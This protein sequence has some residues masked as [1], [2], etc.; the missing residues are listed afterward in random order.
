MHNKISLKN[1]NIYYKKKCGLHFY[2]S[3]NQNYTLESSFSQLVC[4]DNAFKIS[5]S[6]IFDLFH[7][8]IRVKNLQG[9]KNTSTIKYRFVTE[10]KNHNVIYAR[11][12]ESSHIQ[13]T[14][15]VYLWKNISNSV[16]K[17]FLVVL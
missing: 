17:H 9:K 7:C 8:S 2:L 12:I 3:K 1:P 4:G 14:F 5:L 11:I 16:T 6:L 10:A 15:L 13:G